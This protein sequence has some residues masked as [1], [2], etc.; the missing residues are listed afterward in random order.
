[1]DTHMFYKD[2]SII[3]FNELSP[4]INVKFVSGYRI[5]TSKVS[6]ADMLDYLSDNY[7]EGNLIG[8]AIHNSKWILKQKSDYA[9]LFIILVN[10]EMVDNLIEYFNLDL[11]FDLSYELNSRIKKLLSPLVGTKNDRKTVRKIKQLIAK[12]LN[13]TSK[14]IE[15]NYKDNIVNLTINNTQTKVCL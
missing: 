8:N 15:F 6:H 7:G 11:T 1:M 13:I 12:E 4:L 10:K 3:E 14:D 9:T 5:I 2:E